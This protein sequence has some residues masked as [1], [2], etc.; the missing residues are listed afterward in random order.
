MAIVYVYKEGEVSRRR[1]RTGRFVEDRVMVSEG[2]EP[3]EWV[4]TDGAKY[5]TNDS[6]VNAVNLELRP[7]Q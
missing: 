6:R 7:E 3:G 5:I 1:V 4:V 2:L